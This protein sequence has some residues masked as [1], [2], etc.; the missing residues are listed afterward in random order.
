MRS[1]RAGAA[2]SLLLASAAVGLV[3][4]RKT[5]YFLT[6]DAYIIFRYVSNSVEEY[7]LV[8]NPPPFR[9]VEGYTSFLW[10]VVLRLA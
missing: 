4:G 2:R 6:D 5:F 3:V 10:A 8:W 7:G 1:G 9:P